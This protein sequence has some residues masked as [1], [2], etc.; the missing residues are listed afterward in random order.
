MT[1]LEKFSFRKNNQNSSYPDTS[2]CVRIADGRSSIF[3]R[4]A[5]ISKILTYNLKMMILKDL[6]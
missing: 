2:L 6:I 1:A 3:L 4:S 5:A